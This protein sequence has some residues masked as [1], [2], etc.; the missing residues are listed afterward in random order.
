MSAVLDALGQPVA[1]LYLPLADDAPL[2]AQGPVI[3][4]LARWQ[5]EAAAL[6]DH[7]GGVAVALPNTV[8]VLALDPALLA[9]PMLALDFPAFGDGRAY[10]Q[11]ERLRSRC[12][13]TGTLRASGAAVVL[14]QLAMLSRCGFSEFALR[15]DQDLAR[16]SAMLAPAGKPLPYQPARD[17]D[18]S[19]LAARG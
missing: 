14:D 12:G 17:R 4:S 7:G 18:R 6:A 5:A 11:A 1:D 19:V 13:Y 16:C 3:V 2:P 15:A 9:R 10:S 8:D